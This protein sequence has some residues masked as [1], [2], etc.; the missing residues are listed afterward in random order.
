[1]YK[2]VLQSVLRVSEA[3][4]GPIKTPSRQQRHNPT[5]FSSVCCAAVSLPL[6][7]CLLPSVIPLS[8]PLVTHSFSLSFLFFLFF[9]LHHSFFFPLPHFLRFLSFFIFSPVPSSVFLSFLSFLSLI[10]SFVFFPTPSLAPFLFSL[11]P[12][13]HLLSFSFFH[14]FFPAPSLVSFFLLCLSSMPLHPCSFLIFFLSSLLLQTVWLS[15]FPRS[16]S[17]TLATSTL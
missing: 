11:F 14:S 2:Q 8:S 3:P 1:M 5:G 7:A 6:V 13:P 17:S 16:S 10:S 12:L 4:D 9:R 15:S